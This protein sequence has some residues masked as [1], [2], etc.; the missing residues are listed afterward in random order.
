MR[1]GVYLRISLD[2]TGEGLGVER[3]AE[4]CLKLCESR[5]WKS[6]LYTDNDTS[7]SVGV[8]PEYQRMLTDIQNGHIQA[9]VVWDLD[10]LHR[11][12]IELEQFMELADQK[13]I[14]LATVTGDV[15]LSTDNGRLFARIKGAV[16][17][18]EV[19]R[20]SARQRRA[21]LQ[22]AQAGKGWGSR[23]FGYT[24]DDQ[25]VPEEAAAILDGYATIIHGGTLT[26]IAEKWN[27]EGHLTAK[28]GNPWTGLTVRRVL[29]NPRYAGIREYH[30]EQYP[31]AWEPIVPEETWRKAVTI[32]A[33]P[34]RGGRNSRAR[35]GLLTGIAVCGFC[36]QPVGIGTSGEKTRIRKVYTCKAEGC[37]RVQ[38]DQAKV[39]QLIED[40]IVERLSQPDAIQLVMQQPSINT[41][42]LRTE[43]DALHERK[44]TLAMNLAKGNLAPEDAEE[45]FGYISS[46][47]QEIN[48][49]LF[50]QSASRLLD[51][52]LGSDDVRVSWN[53]LTLDRKRAIIDRLV[54]V[55]ILAAPKGRGW[56]PDRIQ[57][58]W[59]SPH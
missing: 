33:N 14:A 21:L 15:D 59:N 4:D 10:R 58:V 54:S 42:E 47:L 7:A 50:D 52:V 13:K 43:A 6:V 46:R 17:R 40:V 2:R 37:H 36:G 24:Q 49:L 55:T 57:I 30:G 22:R 23:A 9:V 18:A 34:A 56:H 41:D 25:I 16:A 48:D 45:A 32:L 19:E 5:G 11:R 39:E 1:A 3:Q 20:K 26:G 35:R 53:E 27:A 38:R 29:L 28:G 12:P 31:A 51:G 8:R 44:K